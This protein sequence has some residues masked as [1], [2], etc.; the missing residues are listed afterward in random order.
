MI[1]ISGPVESYEEQVVMS[2]RLCSQTN[3]LNCLLM[4]EQLCKFKLNFFKTDISSESK[5]KSN[6]FGQLPVVVCKTQKKRTR[7]SLAKTGVNI[8]K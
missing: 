3:Y 7:G 8:S 2:V 4:S 1:F 6:C 5:H